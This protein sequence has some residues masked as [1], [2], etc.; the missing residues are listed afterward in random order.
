MS[1]EL[2][3]AVNEILTDPTMSHEHAERMLAPQQ[4]RQ[5]VSGVDAGAVRRVH[6]QLREPGTNAEIAAHN[7]IFKKACELAGIT[8]TKRQA[9]KWNNKRGA[10]WQKRNEALRASTEA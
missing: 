10:A 1:K 4:A 7:P 6:T 8:P 3:N 5:K 2:D 9:S